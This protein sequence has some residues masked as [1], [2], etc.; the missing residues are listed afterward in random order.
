M[1]GCFKVGNT[2]YYQYPAT[3]SL[4][5]CGDDSINLDH[6][7]PSN[8]IRNIIKSTFEM[9]ENYPVL[10]DGFSI[11]QLSKQTHNVYLP[12]SNMTATETGL[13]SMERAGFVGAKGQIF[14]H[15]IWLV[16]SNE[17]VKNLFTFD[18]ADQALA[19]VAPFA[20]GT[21]VK[22]LYF[23]YDE[24]TL[25]S[26]AATLQSNESKQS[27]CL[28]QLLL[29]SFGYKA[30]VPKNSF[31]TPSPVITKF[32][33]GHD[34]RLFLSSSIPIEIHFS[35]PMNCDQITKTLQIDST[36][37]SNQTVALDTDSVQCR[38]LSTGAAD[39]SPWSGGVPTGWIY[40]ANLTNVS[41]GIHEIVV[42]NISSAD[43]NSFTGATDHFLVRTGQPEN[44]IV[45]PKTANYSSSLLLKDSKGLY[46][47]HRAAGADQFRYSLNFGTTYT[48]WEPYRGGNTTLAPKIW[49]GTKLQDW[50]GEHVIVQYW[51]RLAGSSAHVQQGDYNPGTTSTIRRFAHFFL[52]GTFNQYGFDAG[53]KNQMLQD[54]DDNHWKFNFMGEWPVQVALNAWGMN[55]DGQPDQTRVYGDIDGDNV[56]DRIPPLSLINNVINITDSPPSPYLANQISLND[57]DM[58]YEIIPVGNRWVQLNL[59][60]LLW[61]IPM[62]SGTLGIWL[63]MKSFYAV[64]HNKIGITEKKRILPLAMRRRL[65]MPSR[66]ISTMALMG[67][68]GEPT[69]Y[70]SVPQ[71]PIASRGNVVLQGL[72]GN[73]AGLALQ[74]DPA[75]KERRT[76][77]IATMEYDI[78]DWKIK[79]KIGGLGVMAQ[80]MGKNL[81]HQ[82]LIWVIPCVGGM[83]YP[84]DTPGVPITIEILGMQYSIEVQYHV[85]RNIT[86]VLLDAPIFR[87]QTAAEPYPPRMDDLDSA[88]YYSAWN[89]CIAEAMRRFPVDLYHINDYHGTVAPLHLLPMVIPVCL[90][91]HNAEFQGLWPMRNVD[92]REEV[93]QVYNL[94]PIIVRKYVQFGEVFSE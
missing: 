65:K 72:G 43:G 56:L 68:S 80:L 53:F 52:H 37:E 83:E 15:S 7:D 93:C 20:A 64:K 94:D 82:N 66:T 24:Y 49:S 45:F 38:N 46:V 17:Q 12:G 69:P 11:Q 3:T 6:R 50:S 36:T 30:F 2:K 81:S 8:A 32:L 1:H 33:P 13:W 42:S 44:P 63:F 74:Q 41:D 23:P 62:I 28:S 88:I 71:T 85:L 92:E 57:A 55:P 14:N 22:N 84:R 78:E 31:I 90:S 67:K 10:N 26:S 58:R 70:Q 54:K 18:C 76:V 21:T 87:Q 61:L 86:Y 27:G 39:P 35:G 48:N 16:Y 19:L 5:A 73:T 75:E 25:E 29:P 40:A 47:S 9:R 79:V 4:T 60:I 34:A 51:S 59:Y 91:L 89:Q 77:L